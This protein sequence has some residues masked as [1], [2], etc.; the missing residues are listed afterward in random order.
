MSNENSINLLRVYIENEKAR[1]RNECD[2]LAE[3]VK[4]PPVPESVVDRLAHLNPDHF[5]VVMRSHPGFPANR[6]LQSLWAVLKAFNTACEDLQ[7]GIAEFLATDQTG[8]RT[9]ESIRRREGVI[10][11]V[12]KEIFAASAGAAAVQAHSIRVRS[13]IP[14]HEFRQALVTM[15]D[16]DQHNFIKQ[17]RNNLDHQ[18]FLEPDWQV[19]YRGGE[20]RTRFEFRTSK[21]LAD[22]DFNTKARRYIKSAGDAID[23]GPLFRDYVGRVNT[24]YGWL[25]D[26]IDSHLQPELCDYRRCANAQKNTTARTIHRLFLNTWISWRVDPYAHLAEYLEP[27]EL[28]EVNRLAHRSAA[29]VNRVIDI[30]DKDHICDDELRRLVYQLFGAAPECS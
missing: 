23:V 2:E 18:I 4:M 28:E 9:R 15:F 22:G 3:L 11:K 27:D 14:E 10:A 5:A 19:M 16:D 6:K 1:R 13:L 8:Q 30:V 29:Q 17:L 12:Q 25:R 7:A 24:F 21:L 20:A 26:Q